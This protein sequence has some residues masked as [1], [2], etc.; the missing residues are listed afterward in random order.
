MTTTT[1]FHAKMSG[2]VP[3]A[4]DRFYF[5]M[6]ALCALITFLG[7]APTYWMPMLKGTL[8]VNPIVHIHAF[9]FFSWALFFAFQT[10]LAASRRF[11]AHRSMGL[12]A[13]SLATAMT[14]FGLYTSI[15]QMRGAA[16][17]GL[18]EAGRAFAIVPISGIAFFA[19]MF[20]VAVSRVRRPEW[21]KRLMLVAAISMLD[22]PIA[23]LFI[24]FLAPA[25]PPGPPPVFVDLGPAFVS[26]LLLVGAMLADVRKIGRPH[27]AYWIGAGALVALK[28]LQ[29]PVSSTSTWLSIA[30]SIAAIGG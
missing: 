21:H 27:Q 28:I 18:A 23:R 11:V 29:V 12:I 10:W 22:A 14:I 13:I 4:A 9:V 8:K 24:T 2:F 5:Q 6:A 3:A 25:G 26:L 16:A 1:E 17:L 15:N 19:V 20:A 30:G 7:F